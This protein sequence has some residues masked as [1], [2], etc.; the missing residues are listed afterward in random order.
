MGRITILPETTINPITLIGMRAGICWGADISDDEKNYTRGLDCLESNHGRT[1]E[2][3]NAE[4]VID[5][6]SA[7]VIRELYT[8]IGGSPT[9]LQASTR[10]INYG[11][12]DY[13]IPES[14][15]KNK[16]TKDLFVNHMGKTAELLK[17]LE[18]AGVPR[19]DAS[20][21]LP[22]SMNTKVVAKYNA[23]TL[24]DMSHQRMCSR[25]YWEYRKLFNDLKK[26]LSDYSDEWK[27]ICEKYFVP[28]CD[29]FGYCNE[30]KSCG[31]SPRKGANSK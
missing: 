21:I 22:I 26:A 2:F 29:Y 24:I 25:A 4:F 1:F 7:K 15:N 30:K 28:K 17:A 20:M 10:Y 18:E 12:F 11:N 19:E 5:G 9:R 8:H 14:I 23:R 31:K 16:T 3:V 6:Y 13:I 27:L